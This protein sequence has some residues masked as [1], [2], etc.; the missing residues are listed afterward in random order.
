MAWSGPPPLDPPPADIVAAYRA[1]LDANA[2]ADAAAA[3]WPAADVASGWHIPVTDDL[4]ALVEQTAADAYYAGLQ[5][6]QHPW[7]WTA[8]NRAE[9]IRLLDAAVA[10]AGHDEAAPPDG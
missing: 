3:R 2:R 1:Y 7:Y 9:A 4:R 8:Q 5:V 6:W 10:E